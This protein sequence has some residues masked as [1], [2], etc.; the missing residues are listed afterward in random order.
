MVI[1]AAPRVMPISERLRKSQNIPLKATKYNPKKRRKATCT[2]QAI[3][4]DIV[5][6]LRI[7]NLYIRINDYGHHP[8]TPNHTKDKSY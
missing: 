3:K 1:E 2:D 5:S 6:E 7:K 8:Y 4:E